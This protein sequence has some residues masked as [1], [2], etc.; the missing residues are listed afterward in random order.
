MNG[1]ERYGDGALRTSRN[2]R[3]VVRTPGVLSPRFETRAAPSA[4]HQLPTLNPI[5]YFAVTFIIHQL[6]VSRGNRHANPRP[7]PRHSL[8][9]RKVPKHWVSSNQPDASSRWRS[10]Q[11]RR[12]RLPLTNPHTRVTPP[13]ELRTPTRPPSVNDSRCRSS[14]SVFSAARRCSSA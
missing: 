5:G 9:Y 2:P 7:T 6:T 8:T 11:T 1:Y 12:P 4:A 10:Y 3:S 13:L 14:P